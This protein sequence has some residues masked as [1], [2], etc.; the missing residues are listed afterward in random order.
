MQQEEFDYI[1]VGAGPA[2]LA[3]AQCCAFARQRVLIVERESSIGGLH[4]VRRIDGLFSEHGPRVYS[5]AYLVFKNL[6]NKMGTTFENHFTPYDFG[7]ANIGGQTITHFSFNE[8]VSF[9]VA[10]LKRLVYNTYGRGVAMEKWMLENNFSKETTDYVD[11][12]CRLTDGASMKRYSLY[13]FLSLV[14]EQGLYSLFQPNQP[15]DIGFLKTW[16]DYLTSTG[17]ITFQLNTSIEQFELTDNTITSI[18]DTT[19]ISYRAERVVFA[20]PPMAFIPILENSGVDSLQGYKEFALRTRYITY[21]SICFH[22]NER[23][24]LPKIWGF[25]KSDWGVAFIILSDYMTFEE[26]KTL[27]S[28]AITI[29]DIPSSVTGK[30]ANDSTK[31]ELIEETFRQLRLSFPNLIIPNT[32][33]LAPTI[34]KSNG[35]WKD[36]D[37]SFVRVPDSCDSPFRFRQIQNLYSLGTQN[38]K[39]RYHFTSLESAV[40]NSLALAHSLHPETKKEFPIIAPIQLTELIRLGLILLV[41]YKLLYD[42]WSIEN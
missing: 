29:T 17:Y 7:I 38:G 40:T 30:T 10:F 34:Y 27:I 23:L 21:I 3:F 22:W 12:L 28:T 14:N 33:I 32:S 19:G 4:R 9:I 24:T 5:S 25:P 35:K 16:Q 31:E 37:E 20:I 36:R 11:R 39:E 8:V 18:T 2:G 13:K 42:R 15:N 41:L 6:L 26:S 1:I